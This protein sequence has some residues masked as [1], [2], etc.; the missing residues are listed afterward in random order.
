MQELSLKGDKG[1]P[2]VVEP[3]RR[4]EG[5]PGPPGPAGTSGIDGAPGPKG[6]VGIH[7]EPG[8]PGQQGNPGPQGLPGPQGP[9]GLP[10]EKGLPGMPG[11]PG[12]AG[13][14]GPP[15]SSSE[16]LRDHCGKRRESSQILALVHPCRVILAG[17]GQRER[18]DCRE[19]SVCGA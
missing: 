4:F 14:N 16:G 2:G 6:N 9:V 7:G 5:P 17:K 15:V 3:G 8:P 19:L 18:R 1:E 10:G 12:V 13:A 11:I